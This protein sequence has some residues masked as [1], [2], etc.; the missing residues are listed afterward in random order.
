IE[1]GDTPSDS[2][3]SRGFLE[4]EGDVEEAQKQLCEL[5]GTG[6]CVSRIQYNPKISAIRV[7]FTGIDPNSNEGALLLSQV[8]NSEYVYNLTIGNQYRSA[9]GLKSLGGDTIVNNS[10]NFDPPRFRI[11]KPASVLPPT[12]GDELLAIDPSNAGDRDSQARLA[13]RPALGFQQPAAGVSR[14]EH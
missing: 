1:R 10:N 5:L 2:G 11:E 9:A 13:P 7:D 14:C 4:I 3:P 8:V 12:G 6:D